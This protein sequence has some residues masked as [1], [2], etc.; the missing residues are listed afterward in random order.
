[1]LEAF[2]LTQGGWRELETWQGEEIVAVSPF[3][4]VTLRLSDL[5][6]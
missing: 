2:A 3:D 6:A 4:A 1:M 5:W